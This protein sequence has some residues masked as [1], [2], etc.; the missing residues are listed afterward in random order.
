MRKGFLATAVER[1]VIYKRHAD[2]YAGRLARTNEVG[3][4][5]LVGLA[6][7]PRADMRSRTNYSSYPSYLSRL[8][9]RSPQGEGGSYGAPDTRTETGVRVSG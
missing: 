1:G 9:R 5:G 2:A 8:P 6:G 4:V 7:H 3:P